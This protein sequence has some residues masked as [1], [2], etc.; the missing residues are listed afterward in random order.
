MNRRKFLA[1]AACLAASPWR[2][3]AQERPGTVRVGVFGLFQPSELVVRPG[4]AA[5]LVVDAGGATSVLRGADAARLRLADGRL[6]VEIS[7]RTLRARVLRV[8]AAGGGAAPIEMSVPGRITRAFLGSL[9]VLASGDAL[10]P[11]VT[12]DLD[13][14]VASVTAAEQIAGTPLDALKAQ[15]IAARSYITAARGRHRDFDACDTTHCQ[16]LREPPPAAHPAFQAAHE[17]RR[18]VLAFRGAPIVALY[19]ASCGGRTR[20]LAEAGLP[21]AADGY[22]FYG[23]DCPYCRRHAQAWT[24]TLPLDGVTGRLEADRSEAARLAVGR[25]E[26]WNAVPSPTF[27]V[28]REGDRLVLEGR[29]MGHGI[30]LCQAGAAAF[31]AEGAAVSE[32]LRHYYPGTVIE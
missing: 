25:R 27:D 11:M 22:P 13:V 8:A 24:R 9:Q 12:M 23:V 29:G 2:L 10:V 26:G 3:L 7:G 4:P 31:A 18:L 30:G 6:S 16:F 14:M 20:S 32:I 21:G 17:T 15:A 28:V 1:G 5:A 19:S